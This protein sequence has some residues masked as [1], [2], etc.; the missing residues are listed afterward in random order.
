MFSSF[1]DLTYEIKEGMLRFPKPW[2][3]EV[4]ISRMG[5]LDKEGRETRKLVL[6]THTG[7]QVDAPLHFIKNGKSIEQIQI[8]KLVGPVKIIDFS[9]L[10]ENTEISRKMLEE[11]GTAK[12]MIFK[13]GWGKHWGSRKFYSGYPYFGKE[14]AEY[15]VLKGVEMIGLDSPSPDDS[16]IVLSGDLLG[17]PADSPI[18][19]ILL[20]NEVIIVE[21]LANL[22]NL[23][24]Y[25]NWNVAAMPIK[26]SG[27]DGCPARVILFK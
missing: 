13:F 8:S 9:G 15:L 5:T 1:F 19:K 24:D 25:S 23:R 10:A 21:Y 12:K 26:V 17:T 18:H 14:A 22:E 3:A 27:A 20:S 16:R 6:G 7:T 2:H 4:S 11:T